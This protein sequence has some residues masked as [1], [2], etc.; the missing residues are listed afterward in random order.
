MLLRR[1]SRDSALQSSL[2]LYK[3]TS[4]T[5]ESPIHKIYMSARVP[6]LEPISNNGSFQY[7]DSNSQNGDTNR[8]I[9]S[10]NAN[11]NGGC[12][13]KNNQAK[14]NFNFFGNGFGNLANVNNN[15]GYSNNYIFNNSIKNSMVKC[16]SSNSPQ[17]A[18][19]SHLNSPLGNEPLCD[20]DISLQQALFFRKNKGRRKDI[21]LPTLEKL[22]YENH[23]FDFN[24]KRFKVLLQKK[25]DLVLTKLD[26]SDSEMDR[27]A[28]TIRLSTIH[29][30]SQLASNCEFLPSELILNLFNFFSKV[31]FRDVIKVKPSTL[32]S[33]DNVKVTEQELG[34]LMYAY[35]ALK[36]IN[37]FK[38]E[39]FD[40]K[41]IKKL[42]KRFDILPD[43]TEREVV[44]QIILEIVDK[45]SDKSEA[46]SELKSD[47]KPN[48][49]GRN[50]L[51]G[52]ILN[53]CFD[54]ISLYL[55]GVRSPY[56]LSPSI[57]IF[58]NLIK[59]TEKLET[60]SR[61]DTRFESSV[62]LISKPDFSKLESNES[63][64]DKKSDDINFESIDDYSLPY[65]QFILPLLSAKHFMMCSS[66]YT[67]LINFFI[68][69][70]SYE[71]V[72]ETLYSILRH[73][74]K[75]KTQKKII[76]IGYICEALGKIKMGDFQKIMNKIIIIITDC[77]I[78]PHV[79]L[80]Q[81][82]LTFW[83]SVYI[84]PLLVDN[85]K[86]LFP[87]IFFQLS[88]FT[89]TL[90][91]SD[92]KVVIKS[93]MKEMNRID[94]SLFQELCRQR[95]KG[96]Q[97]PTKLN[98]VNN[99]LNNLNLSSSI[100]NTLIMN[101]NLIMNNT[102]CM[103]NSES[104]NNSF[105]SAKTGIHTSISSNSVL[106][107]KSL[108]LNSNKNFNSKLNSSLSGNLNVLNSGLSASLNGI[109]N[110]VNFCLN[111][112]LNPN[113]N[114]LNNGLSSSSSGSLLSLSIED[115]SLCNNYYSYYN[116]EQN[117]LKLWATIAREASK[118]DR[119]LNLATKLA[120]VQKVYSLAL[121][122]NISPQSSRPKGMTNSFT[123]TK[124]TNSLPTNRKASY[125][126]YVPQSNS[127]NFSRVRQA[128]TAR[129]GDDIIYYV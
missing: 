42:F 23:D 110:S 17:T 127:M 70:A 91:S 26:F 9:C 88:E 83:E 2:S 100:N 29:E 43:E 8:S 53:S 117:C 123:I 46:Q 7:G 41:F 75:T 71:I 10:K 57:I 122:T 129:Y 22:N 12:A 32:F 54:E 38:P 120:E 98:N 118:K 5:K 4:T 96:N 113:F 126:P 30:L 73:F 68:N 34:Q 14:N 116:E 92:I 33:D 95:S 101:N 40:K 56:V 76:F 21:E 124:A 67:K 97:N 115:H 90:W 65:K 25:M 111:V 58:Y 37:N 125:K 61:F 94:N 36:E 108:N 72:L 28:K 114:G 128:K 3:S 18:D 93:I 105:N 121:P 48:D 59:D 78:S 45:V 64:S 62:N 39:L 107:S 81:A 27:P 51:K 52:F 85:T 13:Q 24:S 20:F 119:D 15:S 49:K 60:S 102:L 74:P 99:S 80:C 66:H 55:L 104:T 50:D 82:S 19:I 84:E 16:N 87:Y 89:G 6:V 112:G 86:Q 69:N 103:N 31:I 79:K 35:K 109:N 63:L 44:A 47:N 77:S 11:A 106:I 1:Y